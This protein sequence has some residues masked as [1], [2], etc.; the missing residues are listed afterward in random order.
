[1]PTTPAEQATTARQERSARLAQPEPETEPDEGL[2][3]KK[4][5]SIE[6]ACEARFVRHGGG[7]P[8]KGGG[9]P[10]RS[11][12]ALGAPDY[13]TSFGPALVAESAEGA[14]GAAGSAAE[15][16]TKPAADGF[17][18]FSV[19]HLLE[20]KFNSGEWSTS[21]AR[22]L[23]LGC[24]DGEI[25]IS[26]QHR[27]DIPWPNLYGVTAED[28]R[29]FFDKDKE[30]LQPELSKGEVLRG[31]QKERDAYR[32]NVSTRKKISGRENLRKSAP[33]EWNETHYIVHDIQK[34]AQ[35]EGLMRDVRERGRFQLIVSFTVR[36]SASLSPA[37]HLVRE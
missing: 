29:G 18:T 21:S 26:I 7:Q 4:T 2:V 5:N 22:F 9:A 36:A 12:L 11:Y 32:A 24:G 25:L 27:F 37:G 20:R 35:H 28:L 33:A 14:Q 19:L 6:E 31:F 13:R 34:L 10:P 1:M 16:L 8:A 23:D 3:L 15:D 30:E 17:A